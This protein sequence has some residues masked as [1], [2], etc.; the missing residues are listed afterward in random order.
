MDNASQKKAQ[1]RGAG[2]GA[3]SASSSSS[4]A[5]AAAAAK[6]DYRQQTV[7]AREE[8]AQHLR[9]ALA[10]TSATEELGTQTM[11]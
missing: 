11:E 1:P 2:A 10:I 7:A 9:S 6:P 4:S 3:S 5:A 8:T